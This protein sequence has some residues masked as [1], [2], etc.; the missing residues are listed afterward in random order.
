MRRFLI[1]DMFGRIAMLV[2]SEKPELILIPL[3]E[4]RSFI[5]LLF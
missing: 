5:S 3:G 1:G 4:V 2:L